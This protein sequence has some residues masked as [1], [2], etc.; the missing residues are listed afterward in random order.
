MKLVNLYREHNSDITDV[1]CESFYNYPIMKYVLGE[2][3]DY[4]NRLRKLI[5]FF[6]SAR[7]LRKEPMLGIYN[8][9]NKLVAA[10]LV[11]L[12][13]DI[14]PPEELLKQRAILWKEL[15]SEEKARYENYGLATSRLRPKKPNHHLN[16][17]GVIPA[18]QGKG[19]ARRL[20]DEVEK[21]ASEHSSSS[22]LSLD[23][24]VE[25]NVQFYL[26]LGYDLLGQTNVD[27]NVLTWGFF[28]AKQ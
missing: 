11:T 21:L 3:E 2:K 17:I 27:K 26:H 22:G 1:F 8:D 5:A 14:P 20:I 18:Y 7:A 16:M 25:S 23:T 4:N 15:G 9:E 10:A 19:L 28:K 13:G 12:P 24:E 6:V